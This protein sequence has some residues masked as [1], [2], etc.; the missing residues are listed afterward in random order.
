MKGGGSLAKIAL[1]LLLPLLVY[2]LS[3]RGDLPALT[4]AWVAVLS[5]F[6]LLCYAV[7]K[8][9]AKQNWRRTPERTLHAAAA[10]GGWPGALLA[11]TLFRHKSSK[12]PFQRVFWA[13]VVLNIAGLAM[14]GWLQRGSG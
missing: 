5:A 6:T 3:R 14:L 2:A 8:I 11:Q 1:A 7:D 12:A 9:A 13:T 4:F 10:L